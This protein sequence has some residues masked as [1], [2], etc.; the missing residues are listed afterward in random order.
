MI[1]TLEPLIDQLLAEASS[2][3]GNEIR[4]IATNLNT[5]VNNF[6]TSQGIRRDASQG[7]LSQLMSSLASKLTELG[8]GTVLL[9]CFVFGC[10]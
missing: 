6:F 2:L 5:T 8:V 7:K 4:N 9:T 10:G 1:S 3:V